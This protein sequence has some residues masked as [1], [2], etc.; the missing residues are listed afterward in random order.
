MEDGPAPD[1]GQIPAIAIIVGSRELPVAVDPTDH[2]RVFPTDAGL[3]HLN[4]RAGF[5]RGRLCR[6]LLRHGRDHRAADPMGEMTSAEIGSTRAARGVVLVVE[7]RKAITTSTRTCLATGAIVGENPGITTILS[8]IRIGVGDSGGITAVNRL[9]EEAGVLVTETE[10][11]LEDDD[12]HTEY[13]SSPST[14]SYFSSSLLSF[15]F[16][17]ST[18]RLPSTPPFR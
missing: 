11:Q 16:T 2:P 3:S 7:S 15:L 14:S 13:F 8:L 4:E 1:L 10:T 18:L 12:V 6:Q 5:L 9:G 17:L